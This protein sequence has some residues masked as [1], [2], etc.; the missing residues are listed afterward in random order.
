MIRHLLGR[1]ACFFG[2]HKRTEW[3][4]PGLVCQRPG[5]YALLRQRRRA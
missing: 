3:N 2:A 4:V 1:I 5:C